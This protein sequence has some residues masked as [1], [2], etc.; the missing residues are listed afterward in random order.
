MDEWTNV[1]RKALI[2]SSEGNLR[3]MG[4]KGRE[5]VLAEF[6][7]T[8]MTESFD[9]EVQSLCKSTLPRPNIM[10][11]WVLASLI[12]GAIAVVAGVFLT[13][14]RLQTRTTVPWHMAWF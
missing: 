7:R 12:V 10:P 13:Y 6:N 14:A 4:Q 2:P 3:A 5:R 1:M 11:E 8:K 9:K